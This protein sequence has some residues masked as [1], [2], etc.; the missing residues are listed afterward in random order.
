M[1]M[2]LSGRG[3]LPY[4]NGFDARGQVNVFMT[5]SIFSY[6]KMRWKLF[7]S[8][9]Q[10]VHCKLPDALAMHLNMWFCWHLIYCVRLPLSLFLPNLSRGWI[11]PHTCNDLGLNVPRAVPVM[12]LLSRQ[13]ITALQSSNAF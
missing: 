12:A 5:P 10:L 1:L 13:G 4:A 2:E 11:V 6:L 8:C 3:Q 7:L 9:I